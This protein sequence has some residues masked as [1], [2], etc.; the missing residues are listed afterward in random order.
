M[1]TASDCGLNDYFAPSALKRPN[2]RSPGPLAQAIAFRTFGAK[3]LAQTTTMIQRDDFTTRIHAA[4]I[5]A[6]GG[7]IAFRTD[8][9]YGL[10]V[11]PFNPAAVR[12]IREL[13]RREDAKPILL[14]ISDL[15][16]VDRFITRQTDAFK[17]VANRFWPGPI[18]LIG[19]A[20]PELPDE[21]TAGTETIGLRLAYDED[22]R[23]LVRGCGGAL[24][25]TSANTSGSDPARSATDV[26]HYFRHGIDLILDSGNVTATEP[27]T[28]LDLSEDKPRLIREG[29]VRRKLLA[30]LL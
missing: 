6:A 10:G 28:V 9:F 16:E 17:S 12:R 7:V 18:T 2:P 26:A 22:V 29:V 8:T 19:S 30:D 3:T 21:L 24:T 20:R 11:D 23:S 1:R 14:L 15:S 5:I 27:S 13:K 25:A 4:Q